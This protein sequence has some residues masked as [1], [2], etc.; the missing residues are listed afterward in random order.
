MDLKQ[1]KLS[2]S[3]WNS[4]EVSVSTSELDILHLITSGF[5]DVNIRINKN[6][7]IFTF[8]KI[9]FSEKMENYL[10]NKYFRLA[11]LK[12]EDELHQI[13]REYKFMKI[14]NDAKINS[15][16][17]VRLERFNEEALLSYDIYEFIFSK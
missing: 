11:V 14:I 2:R 4:I 1:I 15:A 10:Y 13:N 12:I 8:L 16:D 9:E 6:N 17:K 5:H 3:E 7:S